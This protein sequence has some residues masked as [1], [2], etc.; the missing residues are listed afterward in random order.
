MHTITICPVCRK[1]FMYHQTDW[2]LITIVDGEE[3]VTCQYCYE[4]RHKKRDHEL[5]QQLAKAHIRGDHSLAI[6]IE[7]KLNEHRERRV[8]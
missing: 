6:K 7:Q 5:A 4:E 3:V 2:H 8:S 1:D